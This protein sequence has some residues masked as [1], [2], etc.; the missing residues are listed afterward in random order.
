MKDIFTTLG[1]IAVIAIL[2]FVFDGNPSVF[3]MLQA[4]AIEVLK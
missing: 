1:W 2:V 3:K 4:K